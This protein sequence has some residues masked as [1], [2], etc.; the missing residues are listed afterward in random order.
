MRST[1]SQLQ[2]QHST[3]WSQ[4]T[5]ESASEPHLRVADVSIA[6]AAERNTEGLLLAVD[7]LSLDLRR[8]EFVA[9]VG[10]SGC[11][12][13]TLLNAVAGFLPISAGVLELDGRPIKK[14]GPDRAMVFQQANLLPWRSVIKNVTYGLEMS[15]RA[16][17][18]EATQ[19][20]NEVLDIVQLSAFANSY[21]AQLSGGMRQRVNLARALAVNPELMLLDEPFA[22]V[23]ALTRETLQDELLRIHNRAA[24]SALFITHDISEAIYLA[25]RVYVFSPRPARIAAVV[26][27][28]IPKPRPESCRRL[29]EFINCVEEAAAALTAARSEERVNGANLAKGGED[30]E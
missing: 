5:S 19:R 16:R 21:P 15:G 9:I 8:G 3:E 6:Y 29:P 10:P 2:E 24:F 13:T 7:R 20:A 27:V 12:K 4:S 18:K 1:G 25:D 23:D 28:D 14:P 22:S 30:R 17:G 26:E 11:G